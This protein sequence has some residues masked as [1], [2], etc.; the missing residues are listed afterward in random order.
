MVGP[1][2][3][4]AD[5]L[6]WTQRAIIIH[7]RGNADAR[8]VYIRFTIPNGKITRVVPYSEEPLT[9]IDLAIAESRAYTLTRLS[10][11]AKIIF[12]TWSA[13]RGSQPNASTNDDST[14]AGTPVVSTTFDGGTAEEGTRLTALEEMQNLGKLMIDGLQ[15][16]WLRLDQKLGASDLGLYVL[17]NTL[18][19]FGITYSVT[20]LTNQKELIGALIAIAMLTG[21]AWLLLSRVQAGLIT[22]TFA[23]LFLW[24]YLDLKVDVFWLLVPVLLLLVAL[25]VAFGTKKSSK[26]KLF[27][28]IAFAFSVTWL[29]QS[30]DT[31]E[32]NCFGESLSRGDVGA[33]LACSQ[34]DLDGGLVIALIIFAMYLLW[35][36][37]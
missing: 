34:V 22:A 10:S 20:S 16:I 6:I 9:E 37:V 4:D 27:L 32:W 35:V 30:T 33:V 24:L 29:L 8:N 14:T 25:G 7:N 18:P 19:Q 28:G 12:M 1:N 23:G 3:R 5:L 2:V 31:S 21:F 13:S 15:S 36:D 26:E 11:G 17:N